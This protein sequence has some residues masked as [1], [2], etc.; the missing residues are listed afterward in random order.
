MLPAALALALSIVDAFACCSSDGDP[1]S[2]RPLAD[3]T[4]SRVCDPATEWALCQVDEAVVLSCEPV[5]LY[6]CADTSGVGWLD[7]CEEYM[8][9][10]RC[11]G[12]V[13]AKL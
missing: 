13:T 6:C 12:V 3:P 8:P 9:G 4:D 11:G 2:C 7:A 10:T 5:S 1:G